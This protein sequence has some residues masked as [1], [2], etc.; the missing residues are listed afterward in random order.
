MSP[1]S[2]FSI[3]DLENNGIIDNKSFSKEISKL[4]P[5]LSVDEMYYY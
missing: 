3:H 5:E 2:A 1:L 4:C